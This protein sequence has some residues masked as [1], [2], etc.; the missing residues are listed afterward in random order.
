MINYVAVK[1]FKVSEQWRE[2][3]EGIRT[4][5]EILDFG[6]LPVKGNLHERT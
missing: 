1:G 5:Y 3:R 4:M 6:F 2:G